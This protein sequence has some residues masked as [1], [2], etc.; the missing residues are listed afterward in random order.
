MLADNSKSHTRTHR[1]TQTH[2][3]THAHAHAHAH[4][5]THQRRA[6]VPAPALSEQDKMPITLGELLAQHRFENCRVRV[7]VIGVSCCPLS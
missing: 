3:H 2:T 1:Q 7:P 6:Q 4:A 5:R